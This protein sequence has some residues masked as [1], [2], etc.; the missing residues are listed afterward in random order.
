[1]TVDEAISKARRSCGPTDARYA[2]ALEVGAEIAAAAGMANALLHHGLFRL[3]QGDVGGAIVA[4]SSVIE[5]AGAVSGAERY[6]AM[7]LTEM[8]FL[9]LAAGEEAEARA[10]GDRALEIL[11]GLGKAR[12][13]EVADGMTVVGVAALRQGEPEVATEFLE[14]ACEIYRGCKTNVRARHAIAQEHAG[15]ALAEIGRHKEAR[16]ALRAA[17]DLHREGSDERIAIEQQLLELAKRG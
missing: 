7:A 6:V 12:R 13:F 2:E 17:I 16:A 4:F 3:E 14:A 1:M 9:V 8:G 5:R 11:L 10:F 15:L